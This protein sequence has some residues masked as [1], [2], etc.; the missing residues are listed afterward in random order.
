[1]IMELWNWNVMNVMNVMKVMRGAGML[2][3][4]SP[5]EVVLMSQLW[6]LWLSMPWQSQSVK[7]LPGTVARCIFT[8]LAKVGQNVRQTKKNERMMSWVVACFRILRVLDIVWY[9]CLVNMCNFL[10][11]W[12]P[13]RLQPVAQGRQHRGPGRMDI[14]SIVTCFRNLSDR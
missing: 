4:S 12:P 3:G 13:K 6:Q 1:M 9:C 14:V 5:E 7:V 8:C 2:L 10:R 11:T